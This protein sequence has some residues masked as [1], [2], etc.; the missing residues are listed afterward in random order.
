VAPYLWI[1]RLGTLDGPVV[2][3]E[4]FYA[5]PGKEPVEGQ[6]LYLSDGSGPWRVRFVQQVPHDPQSP[7]NV[8]VVEPI[9]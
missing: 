3:K 5:V 8:L 6:E 9:A 1:V 2:M 4:Y 7:H